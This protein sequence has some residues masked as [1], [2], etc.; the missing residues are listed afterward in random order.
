M[1][2]SFL[3]RQWLALLFVGAVLLAGCSKSSKKKGPQL[4]L[5]PVS[6]TITLDGK[7]LSEATVSFAFQGT[8]PEGFFGSGAGTDEQGHYELLT[9]GQKGAVPGSYSVTVSRQV[10]TSG[11]ALKPEEGMDME[12]LRQAGALKETVPPKY[13]DAVATD[14]TATVEKG[15]AEGYD[16]K[17]KSG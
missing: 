7:P 5:V 11:V 12:Q 17:L 15:K 14:L 16:F 2:V 9:N 1:S 8:P 3:G 6:G 10:N 13:T 4:D